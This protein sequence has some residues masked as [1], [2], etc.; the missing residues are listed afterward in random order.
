V[1]AFALVSWFEA[2]PSAWFMVAF[3]AAAPLLRGRRW[4]TAALAGILCLVVAVGLVYDMQ[5]GTLWSPYYKIT[6]K[7]VGRETVV[8]VNNIWHQSMAPVDSKEYFYQWPY[9]VSAT[10]SRTS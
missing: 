3:A 6:T 10:P 7:T 8:E 4:T 2:P 1:A 5:R 9:M